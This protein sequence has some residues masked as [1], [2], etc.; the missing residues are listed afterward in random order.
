MQS[1][2]KKYTMRISRLTI[3]KLGIQMYDRVSAVLAELIANAYDADAQHVSI[4]LPFG[5][6]LA[7]KVAG[8]IE[9]QGFAIVIEDDGCGM[10]AQ[11]VNEYYL[12]V[13]YNRRVTRS[14]LTPKYNRRVMGRKGI[15]KLA[16]F[17]ICHEVEVISAGGNRT[18]SGY[19]VSNVILDLDRILDEE[20][21][22]FGNVLPYHPAPGPRDG[23]YEQS[24]GTTIILRRFERRR[25]PTGEELDRQLAAR[26]GLSQSD[27]SVR[28]EDST[29]ENDPIDLGTLNVDVM[30]GTRIA[31]DDRPV[32]VEGRSLP[33]SGWVAYAKDPYKDEVMAGV[34]LY[35]RGKIVA[36]TRDFDIKTGFTGEFKMRSYLTGAIHA[37]WLDEDEDFIRTDRQD[38]IWNS[39][40][41]TPLR[42]WGRDL[43]KELAAKAEAST[44]QRAWDL[45]LE[46]SQLD[47]RLRTAHP[48]DRAIR[49][50]VL[51][52]ARPLVARADRDA[53]KNPDYRDRMVRLAYAIGPHTTLLTTLDEV[54][55]QADG[56]TDVILDL[57]ERARLVETYSLG[58]VAQER[59]GAIEQLRRLVSNPSTVERQ[60][61]KL[62][63]TAP[64]ILHPDW[65][66]LSF[67][68]SLASTRI[69]FH[70]WYLAKYGHEIITSTINNPNKQ[71]D[72]VMLN[73]EGRLE[74]IE[75]KRPL[76]ALS[77]EEFDRAFRYLTAVREFISAT[78]EV[79]A[80]FPIA[81]LTIVCDSLNVDALRANNI[82][83]DPN[84]SHKTWHGL[85]ES[86]SLRHE[87]FL[88]VVGEMQGEL[89][90]LSAAAE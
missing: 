90:E 74:V 65:T 72:F 40:L 78:D 63:E 64:W 88:K 10:I 5:R 41:G 89:P 2:S 81:Q 18:P 24:A 3:D 58:Q 28:L 54:A 33:V 42:E 83:T 4:T 86:T 11:E 14:D 16:P 30:P 57:F 44:G 53:I 1:N 60:L 55:S 50:S 15:G 37:E 8:Q 76:H 29:G 6:Y 51:R 61:Q 17:G 38:I 73:H 39:D 46:D 77:D 35:A 84:I 47:V 82:R 43:L 13:G 26:F 22:Q 49:E 52:A 31:V 27:W 62:M 48:T 68:Q 23:S 36:Q 79:R 75:I 45:F 21:D 25:V 32:P 67:N 12:N 34:R 71:P 85:L 69:N 59:V 9:D 7:R 66:P 19:T 87:D 56:A 20:T 80:S 70:S